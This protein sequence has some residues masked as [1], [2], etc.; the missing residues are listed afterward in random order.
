M[1]RYVTEDLCDRLFKL[2]GWEDTQEVFVNGKPTWRN[3]PGVA[4]TNTPVYR[5]GYLLDKLDNIHLELK[6][7]YLGVD[8]LN[9]WGAYYYAD[10]YYGVDYVA[11]GKTPEE[12]MA[13]LTI[14]LFEKGVIRE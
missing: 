2:T 3:S 8:Y 1:A 13:K 4:D 11:A 5:M 6:H 7:P 12:A 14:E 9:L 10:D